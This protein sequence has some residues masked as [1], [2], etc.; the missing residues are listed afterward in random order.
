M[1]LNVV[2]ILFVSL[3]LVMR[4]PDLFCFLGA[5]RDWRLFGAWLPWLAAVAAP[6][7]R[8]HART[9]ARKQSTNQ[10]RNKNE[11]RVAGA[12]AGASSP[13]PLTHYIG[14]G[15]REE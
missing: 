10:P 2:D 5:G 9:H 3:R 14:G 1:L 11:V 8:M 13:P 12:G 7:A 4:D 6:Q 15:G